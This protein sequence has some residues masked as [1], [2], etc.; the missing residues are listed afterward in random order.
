MLLQHALLLFLWIVYCALHSILASKTVKRSLKEKLGPAFRHYRLAYTLFAFF[1][2]VGLLWFQVQ[3]AS[4]VLFKQSSLSIVCGGL[5][6]VPGLVLMLICIKKYFLSL[7]GLQSLVREHSGNVLIITGVHR[8]IRH[9]LYLGTFAFIWG[10]LILQ[11]YLSLLIAD[12]VITIYTA[13]AIKFEEDKLVE[14]FG[15]AYKTYQNTVPSLIPGLR[16]RTDKA[17]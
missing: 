16:R 12:L 7:S 3:I 2:L 15:I 5:L 6:A 13:I 17:V 4:P 9:P 11:P 14:E 1:S 10:L 8:Y